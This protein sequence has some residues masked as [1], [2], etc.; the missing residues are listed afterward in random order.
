MAAGILR[1]VE[2]DLL[3]RLKATR[4]DKTASE[5]GR[6]LLEIHREKKRPKPEPVVAT[7]TEIKPVFGAF[8]GGKKTNEKTNSAGSGLPDI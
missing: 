6:L 7:V 8:E 2:R 5:I 1:Q 3:R 4:L